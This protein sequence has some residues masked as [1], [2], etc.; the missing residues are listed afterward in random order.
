MR[1]ELKPLHRNLRWKRLRRGAQLLAPYVADNWRLMSVAMACALGATLMKVLRPW[2]IKVLFD[3]VLIPQAAPAGQQWLLRLQGVPTDSLVAAVCLA[4]LGVTGLWGLFSYGQAYL[5]ARAGQVVVFSLRRRTYSHLQR[6]SLSFHQRKQRGDLLMRL[7]GDINVLRDMLVDALLLG[8]SEALMLVAMVS[9]MLLLDWKLTLVALALLPLLALTTFRFSVQIRQ[10][11]RK[12]RKKEGRVAAMIGEMLGGIALIQAYGRERY[13]DK[14]F[15]KSNRKSLKAGLR[16]TRLEASMA[17]LVEVLLAAGTAAVLWVGVRRVQA[18]VLTPGDLLVF[19]AYVHSSYRP[20]RKLARV[21]T[22]LSKAVVCAERITEVLRREPEVQDR[23]GAKRAKRLQGTAEFRRV[24]FRYPGRSRVLR[25]VS[26]ELPAGSFVGLVGPSGA[27]K[28]TILGL[29][30]RLYEPDE[31]RI[32]VD[33]KDLHRYRIQS[34]RDQMSVVLQE[35]VLFGT[36]VRENIAFGKPGASDAEIERAARRANA[37]DFICELP[38][39]YD[40]AIAE[41]GAS[42]SGGQRQRIA[43]ARAFVRD[44][45]ILLLDEPTYGLDAAAEAEVMEALTRLMEGRTALFIAHKLAAVQR[46]DQILVL[47]RRRIHERGTHDELVRQDGWYGR[48]WALQ[49]SRLPRPRIREVRRS[50]AEEAC[51]AV[52]AGG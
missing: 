51:A 13:Q 36:T 26:F 49:T 22:R 45:P 16:T 6:L 39:S 20:L 1:L 30:L 21:S 3:V 46:A 40:T 5:T 31:G 28:S 50:G 44:A 27:G 10:A 34:L 18:G 29:L 47:R 8:V 7:T 43:I 35:P 12:Q 48:M 14:R 25:K 33:G 52:E 17:R 9:V 38:D 19:T 32:L 42:L 2:P 41:A 4:L 37:H 11:A 15:K 23:P 24:S